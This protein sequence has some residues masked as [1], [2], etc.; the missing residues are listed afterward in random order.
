[1]LYQQLYPLLQIRVFFL[2][3]LY[4]LACMDHRA[5]VLA[6]EKVAGFGK[7]QAG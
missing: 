1:M 5:V 2:F 7:R 4:H 3:F 6:A